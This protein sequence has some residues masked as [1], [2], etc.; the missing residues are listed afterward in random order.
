MEELSQKAKDNQTEN[1]S[2]YIVDGLLVCGVCHKKKEAR[3]TWPL[4]NTERIVSV[5]CDCMRQEDEEFWQRLREENKQRRIQEL[6]KD[7][8]DNVDFN[9]C[10]FDMDD[11]QNERLSTACKNYVKHFEAFKRDGKGLILWGNTGTGKTFFSACISNELINRGYSVIMTNLSQIMNHLTGTF[12]KQKYIDNITSVDLLVIDDLGVERG[13]E[14]ARETVYS[15]I[16]ARYRIKR[17]MI[18][19]TN[20]SIEEIKNPKVN[21]NRRI[22]DRILERCHPIEVSGG[23]KRREKIRN[24]FAETQRLLGL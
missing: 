14:Y 16:D 8:F 9:D 5:A 18:I 13:T 1:D 11:G 21:E 22:Y 7:A 10:T 4:D 2:D 23:S 15:V 3:I 6:R 17:P 20:L 24:E 12:E 19:T